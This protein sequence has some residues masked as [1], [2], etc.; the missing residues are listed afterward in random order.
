VALPTDYGIEICLLLNSEPD[1]N[2]VYIYYNHGLEPPLGGVKSEVADE[3]VWTV[4][5]FE[6]LLD[7]TDIWVNNI[8]RVMEIPRKHNPDMPLNVK[9]KVQPDGDVLLDIEMESL[10]SR[11]KWEKDTNNIEFNA[12]PAYDISWEGF[13]YYMT[14]MRDFIKKIREQNV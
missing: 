14:V 4:E 11:M 13:L 9:L 5:Q 8:V 12:R 1:W 10:D 7:A 3:T 2:C 6:G